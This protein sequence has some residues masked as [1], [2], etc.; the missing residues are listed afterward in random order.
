[1]NNKTIGKSMQK[2]L[3]LKIIIFI[4]SCFSIIALVAMF[5]FILKKAFPAMKV[6]WKTIFFSSNIREGYGIWGSLVVSLITSIGAVLIALPISIRIA[7]FIRYRLTRFGR[8]FRV[9]IDILAGVPS[10][11]Y[12]V[13]ALNSL[14][15]LSGFISGT[16]T[17][18][19][20]F[21]A[22]IM[23]AIMIIPTM[24]SLITNQLYLV[25]DKQ[26]ES[27]V[28]LG[29]TKTR[30]I[31]TV[32]LKSIKSG[33]YVAAIVALGR[34]IGETMATSILLNATTP[35][36]PFEKGFGLFN[37]SYKSLATAIAGFMFT[38]SSDETVVE[39]AFAMGL[40]LFIIVMILVALVTRL[41]TKKT[42]KVRRPYSKKDAKSIILDT[43]KLPFTCIYYVFHYIG[44]AIRFILTNISYAISLLFRQIAVKVFKIK[45]E[46]H[47]HNTKIFH[48]SMCWFFEIICALLVT[49]IV[50]WI[51]VDIIAI[52]APKLQSWDFNYKRN[53]IM[54]SLIWTLLLIL[55][56]IILTFPLA[57]FTALFLAEYAK[58]K[59]YGKLI[60]FFLDSLGG[61]PSILFG[62]FGMVM[63][64]E[65][66]NIKGTASTSLMAG[67][68]TMVLVILPTY[69]RSIEQV[70][71][72]IPQ[73][74]RDSSLA[75]GAGKWETI[76]KIVLP[77]A[78]SGIIS[79]TI[80]SISRIISETAPIFLTL[81]MTF[82]PKYGLLNHGQTLTT[83]ILENQVHGITSM[84][85]RIG[86][87]YK[88]AF[89]TIFIITLLIIFSYSIEPIM[90]LIK[91]KRKKRFNKN[92]LKLEEKEEKVEVKNG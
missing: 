82:N 34:A 8:F 69:T 89:V 20:I 11:I 41:S 57:L 77:L 66:M 26:I 75:L 44:F 9:I 56:T 43:I 62:I 21:N 35:A 60:K 2:D 65:V 45:K 38:D 86:Q 10:I 85:H 27:S 3:A 32:S 47:I 1:M 90:N 70:I 30:A 81:G 84:E 39:H 67:S 23:L 33:I 40:S 28:A 91:S 78:I 68:L 71:S 24:V 13:F 37:E 92:I 42:I 58:D 55:I 51:L 74:L 29:N 31:Y 53:G 72:N 12:G 4:I 63:F 80:L 18:I 61:T 50:L 22:I 7:I 79:G 54:N 73:E 46:R 17:N 52:G 15:K 19:T 83:W 48:L 14:G 5:S 88:F 6:N 64:L 25:S 76:R 16:K 36:N 87:S 59:W 49:S